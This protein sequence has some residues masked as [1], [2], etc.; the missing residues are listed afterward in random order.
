MAVTEEVAGS[1]TSTAAT[2]HE[3]ASTGGTNDLPT[4]GT[5][6][7]RVDVNALA[8]TNTLEIKVY[9]KAR[10]GDTARVIYRAF[11]KG[12]QDDPILDM[13]PMP[14]SAYTKFTLECSVSSLAFPW[15]VMAL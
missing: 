8:S 4:G 13:I 11:L 5:Y 14:T 1:Q 2:E 3:L 12:A 10:S 15:A 7:L 9:G 6:V